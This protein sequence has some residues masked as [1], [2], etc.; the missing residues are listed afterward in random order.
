[1]HIVASWAQRMMKPGDL[2]ALRALSALLV[3]RGQTAT[4]LYETTR[5]AEAIV[6]FTRQ[7]LKGDNIGLG[8]YG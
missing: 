4:C 6:Y 8:F 2:G 5:R 1:M 3:I 7:N